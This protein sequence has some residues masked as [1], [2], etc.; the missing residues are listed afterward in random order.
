M[1]AYNATG[2]RTPIIKSGKRYLMRAG[3][4]RDWEE[5]EGV[6][7]S[8][9]ISMCDIRYDVIGAFALSSDPPVR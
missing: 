2:S 5:Q 6:L 9:F 7:Q 1:V 4:Q 3:D 8:T